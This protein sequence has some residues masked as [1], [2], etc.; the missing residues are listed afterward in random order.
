MIQKSLQ[1]IFE[2]AS[3]QQGEWLSTSK[4]QK[5]TSQVST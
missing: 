1:S 3:T 2:S 4:A 5:V